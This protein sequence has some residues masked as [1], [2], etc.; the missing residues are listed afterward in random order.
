MKRFHCDR[1]AMV[2]TLENNLCTRC[3]LR[4]SFLP[5]AMRMVAW[6]QAA[7]E[8]PRVGDR[9]WRA[10]RNALEHAVCNWAV[11]DDD[12]AEYCL[13]CRLT[14]VIPDLGVEGNLLRWRSLEAA[15]RR[16]LIG[17]VGL[18]VLTRQDMTQAD[19]P[20][21][22]QFLADVPGEEGGVLTG[23]ADG[24]ITINIAEADDD[25]RERRR[26]QLGEPYRTIVGHLRHESGHHYWDR[27][28]R[29]RSRRLARFRERFGDER[30]DYG[31]ALEAH[32][33]DGPAPD[34][35]AR[36]VSAYAA[37]HPWE[38]W[39]ETWAHYLHMIDSLE[40][41]H[42]SGLWIRPPRGSDPEFAPRRPF[43][44]SRIGP[45]SRMV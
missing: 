5:E 21:S 16:L 38:D 36:F 28:I 10:C 13:S 43:S 2:L 25:E 34:W 33:R 29:P 7:G 32:Y 45:F 18:G 41:A 20:M 12:P 15:K 9:I 11:A 3:G 24:L 44:A 30:V 19:P 40:T 1:C 37:S 35:S 42:E 4:L 22:F 31:A 23:H 17:L 27:L 39:A 26:V 6:D 14:R 8:Q